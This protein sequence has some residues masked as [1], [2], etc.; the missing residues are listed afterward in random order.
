MQMGKKLR[1]I[2]LLV[3]KYQLKP[4]FLVYYQPMSAVVCAIQTIYLQVQTYPIACYHFEEHQLTN[5]MRSLCRY[6]IDFL[7]EYLS[8]LFIYVKLF[9]DRRL[10]QYN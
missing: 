5:G 4:L 1:V 3:K 2:E 10:Y 9:L 8:R 6:S 7:K